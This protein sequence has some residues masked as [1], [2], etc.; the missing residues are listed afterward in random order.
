MES[1]LN[2][3]SITQITNPSASVAGGWLVSDE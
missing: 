3:D 1:R 2:V